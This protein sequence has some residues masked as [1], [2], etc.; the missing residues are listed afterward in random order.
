M[1]ARVARAAGGDAGDRVL[2]S[3]SPDSDAYLV[4]AFLKGLS[5][6]GYAGGQNVA[7]EFRWAEGQYERLPAMAAALVRRQAAIV[8]AGTPSAFAAKA[9]TTTI[10][11]VFSTAVD[12]VAAGLVASLNRPGRNVTGVTNLGNELRLPAFK[13]RPGP[14]GGYLWPRWR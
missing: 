1:A 11:I 9:A 4:A 2:G 14:D 10:P 8:A 6:A 3:R 7:I 5:E 12:P 13:L